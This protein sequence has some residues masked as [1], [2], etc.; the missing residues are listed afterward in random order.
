MLRFMS[1]TRALDGVHKWKITIM[2]IATGEIHR[3]K[4]GAKGYQDYTQHK[5]SARK[6]AYILRH[7]SKEDWTN[8]LRPGTLSRFI[9]WNKPDLHSSLNDYLSK[10]N[11]KHG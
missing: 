5:D 11:I 8:P 3:I 4:F 10:F 2:D 7:K 9:L 1:L 6:N